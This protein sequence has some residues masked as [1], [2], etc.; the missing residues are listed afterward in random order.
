MKSDSKLTSKPIIVAVIA[1]MILGSVLSFTLVGLN[2]SNKL[3]HKLTI[4]KA[5]T[6][7]ELIAEQLG[8][9]LWETSDV[10]E[11]MVRG[12]I[13][14]PAFYQGKKLFLFYASAPPCRAIEIYTD[15][16][17][18]ILFVTWQQL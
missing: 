18:V 3:L 11:M 17:G 7:L 6:N 16:N 2:A 8:S 12:S 9:K 1:V 14:D 4:A 5:G 15:K 10:D 13:K